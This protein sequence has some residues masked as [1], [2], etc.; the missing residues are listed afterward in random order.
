MSGFFMPVNQ[1]LSVQTRNTNIL[2]PI[3]FHL[4]FNNLGLT[5]VNARLKLRPIHSYYRAGLI[6]KGD[7]TVIQH[8][9]KILA[10]ELVAI[11]QYFLHARMYE[12]W[13]LNKLGKH[14]YHE[15]IDE[16]KH[17][18][19]LIKR[20]LFLEGL[21]NVQDLGKLH[22]GEH[23]R[24]MLEC[25]LRIERTGHADLKAAIAHCESVGDFGSRELLEDILESEEE[26]IDWLETQ[27]GLIDKVG[28]ENYLQSQ[29][30]EE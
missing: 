30:G 3:N 11:N 1:M 6:M 28:L 26:H 27:L 24:E 2:I 25:D 12:D 4:L 10:N 14:E 15:S 23:T 13:G 9:N 29:M 18:D 22:I 7:I 5:L 8:L 17:A 20:I 21:P 19:K 16:M